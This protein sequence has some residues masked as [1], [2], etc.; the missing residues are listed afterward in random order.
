[1]TNPPMMLF[2]PDRVSVWAKSPPLIL[3]PPPPL[4]FPPTAMFWATK[5]LKSKLPLTLRLPT[6]VM[7]K[8]VV[9]LKPREAPKSILMLLVP[10]LAAFIS[11]VWGPNGDACRVTV[12]V[13]VIFSPP[14]VWVGTLRTVAG[15]SNCRMSVTAGVFRMGFQLPG[16]PQLLSPPV[17]VQR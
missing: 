14:M 4:K 12:A 15:K 7:F 11:S 3:M 13:L 5:G 1:M 9:P 17:P 16:V 6:S 10:T 8:G 2:A